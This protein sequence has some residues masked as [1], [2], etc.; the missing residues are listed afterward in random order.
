MSDLQN[1]AK[2]HLM[3]HFSD[4]TLE[5][6]DIPVLVRG[7]GSHIFDD[8]GNRYIDGLSGL[9]C[10]NLGHSH[11]EEIGAAAAAQMATLPFTTNWTTAHPPAIELAE[12]LAELGPPGFER[13]FFTSGGSESVESAYKIALQW[14][15][16]NG[17]P[18]RRK[19]DRPPRRL[20]RHLAGSAL[21][22]R[23]P[24]LPDAV[25]AAGRA[26]H[27]RRQHERLPAPR[28]RRRRGGV[29]GGAARR[30]PRGDRVRD[31]RRRSR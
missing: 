16:A 31:A 24:G 1:R 20:P 6:E 13:V 25:R 19:V 26:D 30:D 15:Q 3:L 29:H 11:G 7:E 14:H 21:V 4:M 8:A 9:Y 18:E 22:H 17:E 12:K 23:H 2:Q 28:R 27:P 5:P 10:L